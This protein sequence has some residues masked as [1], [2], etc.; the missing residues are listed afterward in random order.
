MPVISDEMSSSGMPYDGEMPSTYDSMQ[1]SGGM[2]GYPDP[3]RAMAAV[4]SGHP[5]SSHTGLNSLPHQPYPTP[6]STASTTIPGMVTGSQ[7]SQM[8]MDKDSIYS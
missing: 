5:L 8:K 4:A 3:H 1:A 7:D 6:Y 2:G